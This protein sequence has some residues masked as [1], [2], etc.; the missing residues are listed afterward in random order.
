[1]GAG[2]MRPVRVG[3]I[4][5]G[6]MGRYHARAFAALTDAK[7]CAVADID[8][9][10]V[11]LVAT[12]CRCRPYTNCAEML[13]A[14]DLDAVSV[15]VPT[16]LHHQIGLAA[17]R[18]GLPTLIE[19]PL[20]ST[21]SEGAQLT[22]TSQETGVPLM[23]G[24][25]ERFNPALQELKQRIEREELGPLTSLVARRVGPMP[26]SWR[27]GDVI[28]DLAIHDIDAAIYLIGRTPTAVLGSA[29][30]LC[31]SETLDYADVFLHFGKV[32]CFL[33]A[34]WISPVKIRTLSVT[35]HTGHADLDYLAQRLTVTR[36]EGGP[37]GSNVRPIAI[38]QA[39]ADVPAKDALMA[40]LGVFL[41]VAKRKMPS[42]VSGLDAM[43]ALSV[44]ERIR[45][46][47]TKGP[48]S[49]DD[50]PHC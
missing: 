32:C 36:A 19:K 40:E 30:S 11:E 3:V 38:D 25:V 43:R 9:E 27:D 34:S 18:A 8:T 49:S 29:G 23:V 50:S 12:E 15:A 42:P 26:S 45:R 33:Q 1:M 35:G 47:V 4:G 2:A 46:S 37:Y 41:R 17:I 22:S 5:A 28:L 44:V 21:L 14:E 7:L 20:A 10:R 39:R 16:A 24:H 13:A 31:Q 6:K 48:R